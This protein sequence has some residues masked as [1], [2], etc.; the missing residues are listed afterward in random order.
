MRHS[1]DNTKVKIGKSHNPEGRRASL[2]S[3]QAFRVEILAIFLQKGCLE[4]RVHQLFD[5]HRCIGGA[6]KEWFNILPCDAFTAVCKA[7]Q[8]IELEKSKLSAPN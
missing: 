2:E 1:N 3:G 7:L 8:E 4:A 6:G 5:D